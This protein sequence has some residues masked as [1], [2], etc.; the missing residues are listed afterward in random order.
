MTSPWATYPQCVLLWLQVLSVITPSS[1]VLTLSP[2]DLLSFKPNS[3][4]TVSVRA[5]AGLLTAKPY[6]PQTLSP[7][8]STVTFYHRDRLLVYS[9][10]RKKGLW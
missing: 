7:L 6:P 2:P 1:W 3:C 9:R 8:F 5:P 4:G 10:P